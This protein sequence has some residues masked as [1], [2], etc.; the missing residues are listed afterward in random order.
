MMTI[1]ELSADY[2]R[3]DTM[4]KELDQRIL[5]L[6]R[7]DISGRDSLLEEMDAVIANLHEVAGRL[8]AS[9]AQDMNDLRAKATVLIMMQ[10]WETEHMKALSLSLGDDIMNLP[11]QNR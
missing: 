9:P 3:I 5:R 2:D 8:A 1:S 4:L 7:D 6:S 11:R 10:D